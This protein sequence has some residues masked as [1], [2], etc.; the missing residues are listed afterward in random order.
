MNYLWKVAVLFGTNA[1][2][3]NF[4]LIILE[5]I[6]TQK[7]LVMFF[8]KN[9]KVAW[10]QSAWRQLTLKPQDHSIILNKSCNFSYVLKFKLVGRIQI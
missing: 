2:S 6:L 7:K 5:K 1:Y 10:R 3:E 4:I 9:E 8:N